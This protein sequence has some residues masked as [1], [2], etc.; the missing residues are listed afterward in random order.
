MIAYANVVVYSYQYMLDPKVAQMV[1]PPATYLL[2][3]VFDDTV[4]AQ[5]LNRHASPKISW[6][7]HLVLVCFAFTECNAML[8][9]S[10]TAVVYKQGRCMG[11]AIPIES[12]S[13]EEPWIVSV[14]MVD[15]CCSHCAHSVVQGFSC[16]RRASDFCL[17]LIN[18]VQRA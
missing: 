1:C 12:K 10:T 9:T 15:A 6:L 5:C 3:Q 18:T 16:R 7:L 14:S 13:H 4:A 8:V 11:R 17:G 2:C